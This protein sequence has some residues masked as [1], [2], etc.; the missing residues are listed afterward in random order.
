MIKISFKRKWEQVPTANRAFEQSSLERKRVRV[1]IYP[2]NCCLCRCHLKSITSSGYTNPTQQL[3]FSSYHNSFL[4]HSLLWNYISPFH[5]SAE[6]KQILISCQQN[7]FLCVI[8]IFFSYWN[9]SVLP[10]VA[11]KISR[12]R[13]QQIETVPFMMAARRTL[14]V[15]QAIYT[16]A[17]RLKYMWREEVEHRASWWGGWGPGFWGVTIAPRRL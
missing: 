17:G 8:R 13:K 11:C 6:Y 10:A 15:S 16:E 12:V 14:I 9:A 4:T 3:N 2:L 5:S 1:S 7:L